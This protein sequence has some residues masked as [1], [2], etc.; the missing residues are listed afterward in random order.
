M[1]LCNYPTSEC[2]SGCCSWAG[3]CLC[4]AKARKKMEMW[5][6]QEQGTLSL[7][8]LNYK[9][10]NGDPVISWAPNTTWRLSVHAFL[11]MRA[12][13]TLLPQSRLKRF[14]PYFCETCT[15]LKCRVEPDGMLQMGPTV[16]F[17]EQVLSTRWLYHGGFLLLA[18]V[19]ESR[20]ACL[21]ILLRGLGN[22]SPENY[23]GHW[24]Y[25]IL[26]SA[27]NVCICFRE[28][29]CRFRLSAF[30]IC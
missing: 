18:M 20:A 19:W 12:C 9:E 4:L 22:T 10:K 27:G 16:E 1:T 28:E 7:I 29:S 13:L 8:C 3:C 15:S 21:Q 5:D 30:A 24:V 26:C 6:C 2:E 11:G 23:S 17:L 25:I 14:P